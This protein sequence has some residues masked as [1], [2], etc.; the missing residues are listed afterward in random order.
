MF[1]D[2]YT[3]LQLP[4]NINEDYFK[5]LTNLIINNNYLMHKSQIYHQE[6]GIAQGGCSSRILADLFLYQYKKILTNNNNI[7]FLDI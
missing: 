1:Q 2:Y 6:S 4:D 7:H 3:R 5:T